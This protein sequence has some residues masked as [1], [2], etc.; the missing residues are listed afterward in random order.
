M[1]FRL[2]KAVAFGAV[3]DRNQTQHSLLAHFFPQP[4]AVPLEN[5][6]FNKIDFSTAPLEKGEYENCVFS[7]CNFAGSSLARS[8]FVDCV[9]DSCNL[10]LADLNQTTLRDVTFKN[11]KMVGLRFDTCDQLSLSVTFDNCN[12]GQ[13]SLC[14]V[15]LKKTLLKNCRLFET[16]FAGADLSESVFDTCDCDLAVFFNSNLEKADFRTSFNYALDPEKNRIKKAKFSLSGVPGL[17]QK[18]GIDIER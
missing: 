3:V 2:A 11:C 8:I 14:G 15:K 16:D 13:A 17:L 4:K 12:L 6:P 5:H 9:F 18:Y 7:N 1:D 10:S